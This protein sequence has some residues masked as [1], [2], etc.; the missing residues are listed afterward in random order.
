M[1]CGVVTH[2]GWLCTC[3]ERLGGRM[4]VCPCQGWGW[5]AGAGRS[6]CPDPLL[7]P[8]RRRKQQ[9]MEAE[10]ARQRL[11][12]QSIFVSVA[13]GTELGSELELLPGAAPRAWLFPSRPPG[14]P[15]AGEG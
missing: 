6:R 9:S 11:K 3:C 2:T 8:R 10:E 5:R 12:E 14:H 15:G 1:R 7:C 4:G 13:M